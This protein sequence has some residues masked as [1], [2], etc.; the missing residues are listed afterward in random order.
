MY[1]I[2]TYMYSTFLPIDSRT[3][4]PNLCVSNSHYNLDM[5]AG[6]SK[7]LILRPDHHQPQPR[8]INPLRYKIAWCLTQILKRVNILSE[9]SWMGCYRT[10]CLPNRNM[11]NKKKQWSRLQIMQWSSHNL[12]RVSWILLF[13]QMSTKKKSSSKDDILHLAKSRKVHKQNHDA[14]GIAFPK[15]FDQTYMKRNILMSLLTCWKVPVH[16][17]SIINILVNDLCSYESSDDI[18]IFHNIT[19][20]RS[21]IFILSGSK[22]I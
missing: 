12:M 11:H 8:E 21:C 10:P 17:P 18:N 22:I 4:F 13:A 16:V 3:V 5:K 20:F 6:E 9:Y 1:F 19:R 2:E 7:F 15:H 14:C